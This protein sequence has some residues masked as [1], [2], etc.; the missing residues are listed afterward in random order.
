MFWFFSKMWWNKSGSL[1]CQFSLTINVQAHILDRLTCG[2]QQWEEAGKVSSSMSFKIIV[3]IPGNP[4]HWHGLISQERSDGERICF[5]ANSV[6]SKIGELSI[7]TIQWV[8]HCSHVVQE[9]LR[10]LLNPIPDTDWVHSLRP[11][12][13]SDW[14][15]IS[16]IEHKSTGSPAVFQD[17]GG[18]ARMKDLISI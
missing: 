9:S 13:W 10:N 2:I 18:I 11:G 3:R 6:T 14:G 7:R 8:F 16:K 5:R 12:C 4:I 1:G 15:A 17:N